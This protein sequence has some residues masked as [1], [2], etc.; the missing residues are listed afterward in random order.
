MSVRLSPVTL[1]Y[2]TL[3]PLMWASNAIV[4]RMSVAG[5]EPLISPLTLNAARW[6]ATLLILAGI[7]SLVPRRDQAAAPSPAGSS[8]A[9]ADGAPVRAALRRGVSTRFGR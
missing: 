2:L 1:L 3:P 9:R 4:G 7:A 6:V 5:G 8:A